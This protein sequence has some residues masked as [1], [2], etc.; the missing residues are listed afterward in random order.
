MMVIMVMMVMMI[1]KAMYLGDVVR[2]LSEN[3]WPTAPTT[4]TRNHLARPGRLA[5]LQVGFTHHCLV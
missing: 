5:L 3:A 1:D 2:L 4:E